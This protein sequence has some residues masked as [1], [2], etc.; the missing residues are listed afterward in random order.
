MANSGGAWLWR[1]LIVAAGVGVFLGACGG[2][3]ADEVARNLDNAISAGTYQE[4]TLAVSGEQVVVREADSDL[5]AE[6]ATCQA[7]TAYNSEAVGLFREFLE[8][9][10]ARQRVLE[11]YGLAEVDPD[12]IGSLGEASEDIE[13][14]D[15]AAEVAGEFC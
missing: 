6:N 5:V 2:K 12:L 11:E 15:F 14:S 9:Y 13:S 1:S 3:S 4:R 7:L 10:A 8:R